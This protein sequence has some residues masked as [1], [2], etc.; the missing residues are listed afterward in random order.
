MPPEW[1]QEDI[2]R[3]M[4]RDADEDDC[5]CI[6]YDTDILEGRAQCFRCGR[7]WHLTDAELTQEIS[8][9]AEAD[10]LRHDDN[11]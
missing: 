9:L 1:D 3:D 6:E 2:D 7:S 4:F 10:E 11:I 5:E 8:I